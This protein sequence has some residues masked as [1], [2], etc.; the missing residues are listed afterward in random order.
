VFHEADHSTYRCMELWY[1]SNEVGR[2]KF[3]E[4]F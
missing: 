2:W 1:C 3:E 4:D